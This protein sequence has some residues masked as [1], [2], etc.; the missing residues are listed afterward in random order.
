[1][2][3]R[4]VVFVRVLRDADVF[5]YR[6]PW[7]ITPPSA[8]C[9]ASAEVVGR[10]LVD[11]GSAAWPPAGA[12]LSGCDGLQQDVSGYG[13]A[14][15]AFVGAARREYAAVTVIGFSWGSTRMRPALARLPSSVTVGPIEPG[16]YPTEPASVWGERRERSAA[17]AVAAECAKGVTPACDVSHELDPPAAGTATARLAAL[18]VSAQQ[19]SATVTDP[20]VM[21]RLVLYVD[22]SGHMG[23]PGI[24]LIEGMCR[25]SWDDGR[26]AGTVYRSLA[27]L[28]GGAATT[29]PAVAPPAGRVCVLVNSADPVA[30]GESAGWAD[31]AE[32]VRDLRDPALRHQAILDLAVASGALARPCDD[33]PAPP[34]LGS[35]K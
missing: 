8:A 13:D 11:G 18:Y 30:G 22:S 17:V 10:A 1:M 2:R 20:A 31:G 25:Q 26:G 28:C 23:D 34:T 3:E 27:E 24:G 35:G 32:T 21:A 29:A 33:V 5:V 7:G 19:A 9:W 14:L 12:R 4:R 16:R 6:E 15:V